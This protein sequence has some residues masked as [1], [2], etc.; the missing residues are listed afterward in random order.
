M[1]KI[2]FSRYYEYAFGLYE[3]ARIG[4]SGKLLE[5]AVVAGGNIVA[6]EIRK[7]LS[8]LP[9]DQ[10]RYLEWCEVFTGVPHAQKVDLLASFGMTPV[11]RDRGGFVNVKVGWDGYGSYPTVSYPAGVP[12]PL[13]ARAVE[14]G[15]S[16]REKTPF[17]RPAVN[18]TRKKAVAEMDR[19]VRAKCEEIFGK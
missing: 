12:N 8:D 2:S 1:A 15:S 11:Q 5:T 4:Q 19:V 13:L 9:E 16:V 6:D 10:F 3:L 14:S 17:V 7:R 18:A